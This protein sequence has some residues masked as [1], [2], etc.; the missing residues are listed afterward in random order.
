MPLLKNT[1]SAITALDADGETY[2]KDPDGNFHVPHEVYTA[3]VGTGTWI[4]GGTPAD[5]ARVA[6]FVGDLV[7]STTG[8]VS[9]TLAAITAPA[10]NAVTSLTADMTAVKNGL[11]SIAEHLKDITDAL[12]AAGQMAS[13]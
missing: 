13:S 2:Q 11:A 8:V 6:A 5:V 12:K 3:L 7:D 9:D 10:A 1:N 4:A